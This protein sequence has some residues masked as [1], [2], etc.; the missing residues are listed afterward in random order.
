MP[1]QGE[2]TGLAIEDAV[3]F[4]R[5]LERFP[6]KSIL[7]AFETYEKTRRPRIVTAYQHATAR[8]RV[9]DKSW[10][11]TKLEEWATSVYL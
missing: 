3:L 11:V 10:L 5:I 9:Y 8:W 6:E 1:P 7:D 2:S 4:A